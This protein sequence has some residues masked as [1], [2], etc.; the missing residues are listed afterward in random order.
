MANSSLTQFGRTTELNPAFD[1]APHTISGPADYLAL[2]GAY[3][4]ERDWRSVT[5]SPDFPTVAKVAEEL[6]P[7]SGLG[8]IDGVIAVDP[9]GIAALL[10]LTGP[11][12]VAGRDELLTA[13]NA[14]AFLLRGQYE[15]LNNPTRIDYLDEAGHA[16]ADRLTHGSLPGLRTV[17]HVLGRA[18]EQGH[19]HLQSNDP[20]AE[21]L[22]RRLGASGTLVPSTGDYVGLTT[23]NWSGNK[24]ELFL[25]RSLRYDVHVDPGTG[26]ER[27]TATITLV[28]RAPTTGEPDYVIG[29][30][31]PQVPK[32]ANRSFVSFYTYLALDHATLQGQPLVLNGQTERG[33]NVYSTMFTIPSGAT[34]T[35][36]LQLHGGARLVTKGGDPAVRLTVGHQVMPN[37]D[38]V[39]VR[40]SVA[41]D[42]SLDPKSPLV[43]KGST[44]ASWAA[45]LEQRTTLRAA[46]SR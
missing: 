1:Q 5:M 20:T 4:P 22:F 35:L 45:L 29:S 19:I 42:W 28:N 24:I 18:V 2:Y 17:G 33:M 37:P 14:A 26:E 21:R 39:D 7:Q 46:L 13:K 3:Q 30:S 15:E 11:V 38:H 31:D 41:G 32:G 9:E 34:A 44:T 43:A 40:V 12:A 6:A 8:P 16:V 10:K 27:A 36:R 25:D 23:Q